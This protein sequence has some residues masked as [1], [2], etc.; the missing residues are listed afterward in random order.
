[1]SNSSSYDPPVNFSLTR[2][3]QPT[4]LFCHGLLEQIQKQYTQVCCV[5]IYI[6]TPVNKADKISLYLQAAGRNPPRSKSAASLMFGIFLGIF[7]QTMRVIQ[8]WL[9]GSDLRT[10]IN[11]S[12]QQELSC[13]RC[14]LFTMMVQI[15]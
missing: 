6:T 14:Y 8:M 11:P 4:L 10:N 13:F 5:R 3:N 1:M 2:L 9:S 12:H 15:C 7:P